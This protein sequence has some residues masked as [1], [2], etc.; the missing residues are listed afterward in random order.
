[1]SEEASLAEMLRRVTEERDKAEKDLEAVTRKLQEVNVRL[2]DAERQ[3]TAFLSNIRNE[4]N[5][6][7]TALLTLSEALT[8]RIP[9]DPDMARQVAKSVLAEARTLD[10]H[11]HNVLAAA[12]MEAGAVGL[13]PVRLSVQRTLED[14]VR[15]LS[16]RTEDRQVRV[17][18]DCPPDLDLV[19]DGEK[20]ALIVTN[21]VSNAI[22]FNRIGGA[23]RIAA[24]PT[25][26]NSASGSSERRHD[27]VPV[28]RERRTYD[29]LRLTVSD[30]GI[31]IA[32]QDLPRIFDRF[33][34]LTTGATKPYRGNGIGLSVVQ[35]IVELLNGQIMVDSEPGR[36]S[37]FTV[38]VPTMPAAS[39]AGE[40]VDPGVTLFDD[41]SDGQEV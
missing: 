41:F 24:S 5:N 18:V 17:E 16:H 33:R 26:G 34:Q 11:L 25:A 13:E 8:E 15:A 14:C 20:L 19:S 28:H 36:G 22:E 4:M 39:A 2:T 29:G 31:G 10:F 37:A 3:K 6:P 40:G 38:L 12:E 27:A 7:L 35:A 21:L 23:V 32:K 9:G 1:M 30:E